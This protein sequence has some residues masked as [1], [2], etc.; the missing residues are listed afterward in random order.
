MNN[1]KAL[2]VFMASTLLLAGCG[3]GSYSSSADSFDGGINS[4]EVA[5]SA[6][7]DYSYD[8]YSTDDYEYEESY[9]SEYEEDY[10]EDRIDEELQVEDKEVST[11]GAAVNEEKLVYTCNVSIDTLEYDGALSRLKELLKQYDGF[12]ESENYSD[13]NDYSYDYYYVEPSEKHRNYSAT[14]R[15][16]TA[17]Y[18]AMLSD[19]EQIGDMRS[20]SANVDNLTQEYSDLGIT[21]DVLQQTYDRYSA[22][23]ETATDEEYILQIQE[24]LTDTQIRIEQVKSRMNVINRD[25]AYSTIYVTLREV[26]EY[27]AEPEP[28]DTFVQRLIST[29]K[30]SF[31]VF[32]SFLEGLLF[33]IIRLL[34]FAILGLLIFLLVRFIMKKAGYTKERREEKKRAKAEAKRQRQEENARRAAQYRE[35]QAKANEAKQAQAAQPIQQ[36]AQ[37]TP[38]PTESEAVPGEDNKKSE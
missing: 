3:G 2:I 38:Q 14:Y 7:E 15:V 28:T 31:S 32:L 26:R 1:K 10:S 35:N 8:D 29:V 13:G 25:V 21:L 18:E 33:L 4:F 12:L 20:K 36:A 19:M 30:D 11:S 9:D 24:K 6:A 27:E 22:L 17:N 34:P 5:E 23:M 16:P 37:Q